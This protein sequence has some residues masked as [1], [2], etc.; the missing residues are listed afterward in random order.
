MMKKFI[1]W[2]FLFNTIFMNIAWAAQ[3]DFVLTEIK[4]SQLRPVATGDATASLEDTLLEIAIPEKEIQPSDTHPLVGVFDGNVDEG[5]SNSEALERYLTDPRVAQG[6][7]SLISSRA[8]IEP[9]FA[10]KLREAARFRD[11]HGFNSLPGIKPMVWH[12]VPAQRDAE[13]NEGALLSWILSE[14]PDEFID[15]FR[16]FTSDQVRYAK[17]AEFIPGPYRK[18]FINTRSAE[19]REGVSD[20]ILEFL[21][22]TKDLGLLSDD[23]PFLVEIGAS[24][25]HTS[26][27][28]V[29]DAM[30]IYPSLVYRGT[31]IFVAQN[32]VFE[33]DEFIQHDI[34]S[35]PLPFYQYPDI[36]IFTNVDFHL[37][38]EG[39]K[40][41]WRHIINSTKEGTLIL[42]G[43]GDFPL[44][45]YIRFKN[46]LVEISSADDAI[47]ILP[48]IRS[49]TVN[50]EKGVIS[51]GLQEASSVDLRKSHRL[52]KGIRSD[53]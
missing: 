52:E 33:E 28:Y 3:Y 1:L 40:K 23:T 29:P 9:G 5:D 48:A 38:V 50:T 22:K 21:Q 43:S 14:K 45:R 19:Y 10:E 44:H 4:T 41:A 17:D 49:E 15:M 34:L 8:E 32:T 26:R 47:G 2:F 46:N 39:K 53:A 51:Q 37:S 16:V 6:I 27:Q 36:I 11:E 24:S 7:W 18:E 31:D 30:S 42:A 35:S 13:T 20:F 25:G 12:L